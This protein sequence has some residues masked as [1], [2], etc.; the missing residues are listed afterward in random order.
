MI[1][2]DIKKIRLKNGRTV[3]EQMQYE[4]KRFLSI[5]QEEIDEWYRQYTPSVYQRTGNMRN[6]VYVDDVVDVD[7]SGTQLIVRV[8]YNDGAIHQSLWGQDDAD[9]LM[10]MNNGY[11]VSS[12][13]HKDIP[14]FGFR[15]GGHFLERAVE[16]FNRES[17]F[18]IKVKFDFY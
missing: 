12:G 1:N 13:W 2:I 14:Y 7:V 6:S 5:L 3:E 15:Q 10:L 18:G 4:A 16:R 11:Q 8:K 9:T 17:S